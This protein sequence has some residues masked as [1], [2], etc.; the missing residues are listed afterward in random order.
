MQSVPSHRS[1]IKLYSIIALRFIFN[2]VCTNVSTNRI[3]AMTWSEI[4]VV[5]SIIEAQLRQLR[6]GS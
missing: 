1:F 5:S 3:A 6:L 4:L 2:Y